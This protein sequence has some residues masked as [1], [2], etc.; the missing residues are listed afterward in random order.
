VSSVYHAFLSVLRKGDIS[1]LS[2]KGTF[3][4]WVDIMNFLLFKAQPALTD[5]LEG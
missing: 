1:T 3:L 5:P 2:E 4:L